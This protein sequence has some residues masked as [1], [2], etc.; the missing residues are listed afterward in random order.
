MRTYL[1]IVLLIAF[2]LL[3]GWYSYKKPQSPR[4]T[5]IYIKPTP[6]HINAD[7]LSLLV[8]TWRIN[9]NLKA[10]TKNEKLCSLAQIRLKTIQTNWSHIGFETTIKQ[11]GYDGKFGENLVREFIRSEDALDAWLTSS[12][13]HSNLS[14]PLFT[15]TCI[16]CQQDYCA[17]EFS[18]DF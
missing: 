7:A 12:T 16:V 9:N 6:Q 13:H 5:P 14:N 17:Q 18:S 10:F 8:N 11:L 4:P 15:Q 2:S 1:V 3:S